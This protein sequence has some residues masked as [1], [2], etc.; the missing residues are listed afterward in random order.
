MSWKYDLDKFYNGI[1]PIKYIRDLEILYSK[2]PVKNLNCEKIKCI[3][4]YTL[5]KTFK[6][7]RCCNIVLGEKFENLNDD[8]NKC[9]I[10]Y[11]LYKTYYKNPYELSDELF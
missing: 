10:K 9:I 7:C 11:K 1:Y 5:T 4:Y 3:D 8:C 6:Y 2:Y